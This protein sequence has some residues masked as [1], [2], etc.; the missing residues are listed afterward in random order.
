MIP[1]GNLAAK[2]F[3]IYS[4]TTANVDEIKAHYKDIKKQFD[5]MDKALATIVK[6]CLFI[7]II[8]FFCFLILL[9]IILNTH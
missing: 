3:E 5:L 8:N 2:I 7:P 6:L 9:V 4:I 1:E